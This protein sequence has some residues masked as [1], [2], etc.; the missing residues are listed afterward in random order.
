MADAKATDTD[1][2]KRLRNFR[3]KMRE[4]RAKRAMWKPRAP[5]EASAKAAGN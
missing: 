1:E 3:R 5:S 4:R 2:P